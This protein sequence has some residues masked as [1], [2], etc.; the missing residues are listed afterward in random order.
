TIQMT[1]VFA[2]ED[3]WEADGSPTDFATFATEYQDVIGTPVPIT[4]KDATGAPYLWIED[5]LGVHA[6]LVNDDFYGPTIEL[7]KTLADQAQTAKSAAEAALQSAGQADFNQGV[8]TLTQALAD[9]SQC[10]NTP[11]YA[12]QWPW[13]AYGYYINGRGAC[14]RATT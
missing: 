7:Q 6:L 3:R 4:A 9:Q 11:D 14:L 1:Q 8:S 10:T 13:Y 12:N 5:F 2:L